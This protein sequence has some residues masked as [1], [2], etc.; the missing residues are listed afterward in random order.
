MTQS[1]PARISHPPD[2][3]KLFL[4]RA[5]LAARVSVFFSAAFNPMSDG[6]DSLSRLN[7]SQACHSAKSVEA[8]TPRT[9]KLWMEIMRNS[10]L[11]VRSQSVMNI[12]RFNI[13]FVFFGLF[14]LLIHGTRN[15]PE[16]I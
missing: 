9:Q 11:P 2:S 8:R 13:H 14:N 4:V 5:N 15:M 6:D 12:P 10:A 3:Y 7:T 16:D 1:F